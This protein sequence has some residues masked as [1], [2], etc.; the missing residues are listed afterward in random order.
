MSNENKSKARS[1][2]DH[3]AAIA[4]RD[5]EIERLQQYHGGHLPSCRGMDREKGECDCGYLQ[6]EAYR[7]MYDEIA[8]LTAE[9]ERI[10]RGIRELIDV[11]ATSSPQTAQYLAQL[12]AVRKEATDA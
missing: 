3:A 12:I 4:E 5:A 9:V 7:E 11:H 8:R 6:G 2:I 10:K 1:P